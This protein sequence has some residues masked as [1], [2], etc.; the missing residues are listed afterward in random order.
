MQIEEL[1]IH[2]IKSTRYINVNNC[3]ILSHGI[4]YDREWALFDI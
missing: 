3:R 2:P 4:Q 1:R